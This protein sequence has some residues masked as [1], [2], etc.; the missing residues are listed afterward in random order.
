MNQKGADKEDSHLS[1]HIRREEKQE[2]TTEVRPQIY[3][4]GD[5]TL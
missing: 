2:G 3:G 1:E 5:Y 4:A